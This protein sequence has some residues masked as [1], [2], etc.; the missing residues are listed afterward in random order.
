[1][2]SSNRVTVKSLSERLDG[3]DEKLAAIL[4]AVTGGSPAVAVASVTPTAPAESTT[5][6]ATSRKR[7][8][9]KTEDRKAPAT[10]TFEG[11]RCLTK[12]NRLMFIADHEW[13]ASGTPAHVLVTEVV[14]NHKPLMGAWA[15]GPRNVAK[16]LGIEVNEEGTNLPAPVTR[17][18]QQGGETAKPSQSELADR[19][20]AAGFTPD[21]IQQIRKG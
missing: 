2:T 19:L 15:I 10:A 11:I 4:V 1:M 8:A 17:V 7:G 16:A 12:G 13:A 9:R 3:Q 21:E 18:T 20:L 14:L 5:K 6:T